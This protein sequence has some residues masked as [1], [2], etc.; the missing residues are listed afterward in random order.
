MAGETEAHR[1]LK[2]L[3]LGWAREQGW[4]IAAEE[5]RVPRSGCRADV[6]AY[7]PGGR[8][9]AARTALFECKQARA[10][11]LKD[12]HDVAATRSRLQ[13]LLARRAALE[14]LLAMHRPDL[15][16]GESLFPE[17]DAWDFSGLEHR[18]YHA[19]LAEIGTLQTRLGGGTKFSRLL[20]YRSADV[21]YLVIEDNI[22][23]EAEIPAGWGLLVR[24]ADRL[25]LRRPPVALDAGDEQRRRL[26]E[27]I[28]LK[29]TGGRPPP[30]IE[31]E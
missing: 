9:G 16:R 2:V 5:V 1:R 27:S 17:Y 10:D 23:A 20:R 11:L 15:R 26:L 30:R 21:L 22:H 19:L 14:G 7:A 31:N 6:A 13:E 24:M 18:A 29:A 12:A 28:A 25:E 8:G 3:A 4:R